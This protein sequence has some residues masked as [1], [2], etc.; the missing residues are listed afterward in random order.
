MAVEDDGADALGSVGVGLALVGGGVG[1][2]T[3][4]GLVGWGLEAYFGWI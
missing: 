1:G 3:G 2:S 4:V